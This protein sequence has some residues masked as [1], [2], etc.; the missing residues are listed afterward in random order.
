MYANL[1]RRI[2][3]SPAHGAWII[4]ITKLFPTI[5]PSTLYP[6]H[7]L[8]LLL[9]SS[10]RL[11]NSWLCNYSPL[12]PNYLIHCQRPV[13]FAQFMLRLSLEPDFQQVSIFE[14]TNSGKSKQTVVYFEAIA[15]YLL[16]R[17]P[18]DEDISYAS[19]N[20]LTVDIV[21]LH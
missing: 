11:A 4:P 19:P 9:H 5:S 13:V 8:S 7:P 2:P 15:N 16:D 20:I 12:T 1:A 17:V 10:R 14:S 3:P 21:I 18:S 6:S